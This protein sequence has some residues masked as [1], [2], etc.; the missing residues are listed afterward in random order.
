MKKSKLMS[1]GSFKMPCPKI[2]SQF[3][4]DEKNEILIAAIEY[5]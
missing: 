5:T 4:E 3:H 2:R 1:L